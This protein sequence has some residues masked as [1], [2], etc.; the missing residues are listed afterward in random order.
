MSDTEQTPNDPPLFDFDAYP[1]DTFFHE[2]RGQPAKPPDDGEPTVAKGRKER[3]RRGRVDPT[4][5]EKQYSPDEMEF[6]TAMHQFKQRCN[7]PFPTY[8]EVLTVAHKLGYRKV[9]I[10]RP[11]A[12][13]DQ[14][15]GGVPGE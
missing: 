11:I 5:F 15:D 3:R 8:G 10:A 1:K 12:E 7:K 6:M 13:L 9:G 2:R 4:T 14:L